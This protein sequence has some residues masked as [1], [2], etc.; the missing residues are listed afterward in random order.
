MEGIRERDGEILAILT[1]IWHIR[2]P[3]SLQAKEGK[4]MAWVRCGSTM[5][6]QVMERS[7]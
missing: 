6:L 7:R 1:K 3:P 4:K 5:V 2:P